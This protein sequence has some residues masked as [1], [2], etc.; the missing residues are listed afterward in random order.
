MK[1]LED[2]DGEHGET[3]CGACGENYA[4]DKFWICCDI[5]EKWFHGKYVKINPLLGLSISSSTIGLPAA[6]RKPPPP[7]PPHDAVVEDSSNCLISQNETPIRTWHPTLHFSTHIL[8]LPL[9]LSPAIVNETSLDNDNC[10]QCPESVNIQN[11]GDF[12]T[13]GK[14]RKEWVSML[15]AEK[16]SSK[17]RVV[18][19]RSGHGATI[20][21]HKK[22]PCVSGIFRSHPSNPAS[23]VKLPAIAL[24]APRKASQA[25]PKNEVSITRTEIH[26]AGHGFLSRQSTQMSNMT[27]GSFES[28]ERGYLE[29]SYFEISDFMAMDGWPAEDELAS[30]V[31]G[32]VQNHLSYRENQVNDYGGSHEGDIGGDRRSV[33]ETRQA[34]ERV[35]FKTKSAI[36]ILNDGFKWRKYGKKIVKDNPNPRNYY[37]C[38]SNGC[39]VK[40]RVERDGDDP[41]FV[42]TTYHGIH[43]HPCPN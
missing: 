5:C 35:A 18:V 3:P 21:M 4:S 10:K 11:L 43:N 31:S 6:T 34:K 26:M 14:D 36:E 2:E 19:G 33:L 7:P 23:A 16:G 30:V 38:L 12:S 8:S 13:R 27:F 29:Q 22:I 37:R 32:H 28:S 42:I 20:Q 39:P 25:E 40:K 1:G 9:L 41:S 24:E 15:T 17:G